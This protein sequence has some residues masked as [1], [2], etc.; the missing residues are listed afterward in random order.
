MRVLHT[1]DI[2]VG[3]SSNYGRIDPATGLN[4]RLMDFR[5][6]FKFMV[7]KALEEKIDVFLFCGDA[8][9]T[10]TPS[11]TEQQIFAECLE[12]IAMAGIPI[13][14]ITGNHDHP[15]SFGKASSIDIFRHLSGD[16]KVFRKLTS[17]TI[18]TSSGP[19]QIIALPWP[20]RS[21]LLVGKEYRKVSPHELNALMEKLYINYLNAKA[22]LLDPDVPTIVAGHFTVTGSIRGGS[23]RATLMVQEPVFTPSQLAPPPVDYVALGHIHS[24]Q[25]CAGP[26][27]TPVVYC[28]SIERVSFNEQDSRKGFVIVDIDTHPKKTHYKF[29]DTPARE[30]LTIRVDATPSAD[31]TQTIL[32]EIAR[33]KISG[34]VV[35]LLFRITETQQSLINISKIR[36]TLSNAFAIASIERKAELAERKQRVEITADSALE[37][38]LRSYIKENPHLSAFKDGLLQKAMELEQSLEKKGT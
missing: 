33:Q 8:Y 9:R 30:F 11:P 38:A 28:S 15:A 36:R 25:N 22:A 37:E 17:T 21:L 27:E 31:P 13:V 2:H 16:V 19:L 24:H 14:M 5:R 34:A 3:S 1:A 20:V 4:N 35:R 23:E 29:I 12:P 10:A 26:G 6:C 32:E 18:D 7:A